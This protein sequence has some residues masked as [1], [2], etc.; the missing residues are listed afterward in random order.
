MVV[1]VTYNARQQEMINALTHE[2]SGFDVFER[3]LTRSAINFNFINSVGCSPEYC[4]GL[5]IAVQEL[6]WRG[7]GE[8]HEHMILNL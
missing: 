4:A 1:C 8:K 3:D 7:R 5:C 6:S 2:M